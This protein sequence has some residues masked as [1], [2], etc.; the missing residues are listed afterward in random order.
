[1]VAKTDINGNVTYEEKEQLAKIK[2]VT[3]WGNKK[4]LAQGKF[5]IILD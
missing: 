4:F 5:K 1:M 2:T 3:K